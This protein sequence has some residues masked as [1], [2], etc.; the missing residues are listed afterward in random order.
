MERSGLESRLAG[1]LRARGMATSKNGLMCSGKE[2]YSGVPQGSVFDLVLST[3]FVNG[4]DN[5]D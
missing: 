2:V 3:I 4:L 5:S 1:A